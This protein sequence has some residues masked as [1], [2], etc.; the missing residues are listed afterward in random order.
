ML[1]ERQ[2]KTNNWKLYEANYTDR[3]KIYEPIC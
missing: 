1:A 3:N 2:S